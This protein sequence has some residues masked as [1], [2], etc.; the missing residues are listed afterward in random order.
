ML[1]VITAAHPLEF[2]AAPGQAPLDELFGRA[3]RHEDPPPPVRK[4]IILRRPTA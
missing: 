1:Y 4:P 3:A 2:D